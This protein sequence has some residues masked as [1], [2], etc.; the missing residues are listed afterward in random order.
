[1]RLT[2]EITIISE[3]LQLNELDL[4]KKMGV[5]LETINNLKFGRKGIGLT[6]L[7]KSL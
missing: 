3:V 4:S 6:N 2:N 5:S 1:M 7:E